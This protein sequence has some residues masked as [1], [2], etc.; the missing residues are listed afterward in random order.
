MPVF[1]AHPS[2]SAGRHCL[3]S[4]HAL[5]RP[6][7]YVTFLPHPVT[8]YHSLVRILLL[9]NTHIL[10]LLCHHCAAA[11]PWKRYKTR[12]LL[13]VIHSSLHPLT[14]QLTNKPKQLT[15]TLHIDHHALPLPPHHRSSHLCSSSIGSARATGEYSLLVRFSSEHSLILFL[16]LSNRRRAR[17]PSTL[18]R[19]ELTYIFYALASCVSDDAY[20]S[21]DPGAAGGKCDISA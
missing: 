9:L 20:H 6:H 4:G 17:H 15:P 7:T 18:T 14:T 13:M 16:F 8:L 3:V 12:A 2:L 11:W 21:C 1:F 19:S 10:K 5:P